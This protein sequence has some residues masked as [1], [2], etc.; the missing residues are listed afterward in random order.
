MPKFDNNTPF[1]GCAVDGTQQAASVKWNAEGEKLFAGGDTRQAR[2][3]FEKAVEMD[4]QNAKAHNNLSVVDWSL[5]DHESSLQYLTRALELDPNDQDVILNCSRVFQ[6][7]GKKEDALDVL[8]AYL[9]RKPW[10]DE[11]RREMLR[12]EDAEGADP[13]VPSR[14]PADL[15]ND[16][17]EKR[18]EQG[19]LEH[20]RACFEI[21][22][23]HNPDHARAHSN[24]GVLY[25]QEGDL[26]KA[27]ECFYRAL[28]LD[29]EDPDIL[30]NSANALSSAG[31]IE[32]AADLLKIYLQ[33]NPRDENAW[34][35]YAAMLRSGG[36][37]HWKPEGL[38]GELSDVYVAMG[39]KLAHAKD[40]V[41]AGE[42]F[43]RAL[44]L[45][46]G[47]ADAYHGLGCIHRELDQVESALEMFS[48]SLRVDPLHK[49]SVLASGEVLVARGET[50][51]AVVLFQSFLEERKDRDVQQALKKIGS[52]D[53]M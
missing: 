9:E 21:A 19:K 12:V 48:E 20:A 30:Y 37:G 15:F 5:G 52:A 17:G 13:I 34:E 42:A 1:K 44:S 51:K 22:V 29:S 11:V 31:E 40:W 3:C 18:F 36:N 35:A 10:D 38:P 53:A 45:D 26:K 2:R 41:G 25:W 23:E 28:D 8:R 24:L 39:K 47:K 32:I 49:P 6:E 27:L 14:D 33:K 16:E 4:P 46:P 7:L 43:S 50:G